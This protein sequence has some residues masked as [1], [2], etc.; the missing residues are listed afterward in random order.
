MT[1]VDL[2]VADDRPVV[3]PVPAPDLHA[4]T[5]NLRRPVPHLRRDHPDRWEFRRGAVRELIETES[6]HLLGLQEVLADQERWLAEALSDRW[7]RVLE[8]RERDGGG[9]QVGLLVDAS[10]LRVVAHRSWALSP[11]PDRAG[12]RGWGSLFPRRLVGAVLADRVVGTRFL[13]LA[14]HL[15]VLSATARRRSARLIVDVARE[16]AL[17]TL[18]L[19]DANAAAGS[20]PHRVLTADGFVDTWDV[21]RSRA[22]P[23]VG[24]RPDYRTPREDGRRIDWVLARGVDGATPS[25]AR[26]AISSRRPFGVWPSDHAAVHAVLRW[27]AP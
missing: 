17:P 1:G 22:T 5:L 6:P 23:L 25:V 10:R 15:D 13:A 7:E 4:M 2:P 20:A 26:A 14:A 24:T 3:G 18:L 11:E 16:N 27:E 21:A 19:T 12:S 8:G 9:E